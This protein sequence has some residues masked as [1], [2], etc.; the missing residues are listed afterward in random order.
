MNVYFFSFSKRNN[1]TK[2]PVLE[3]GTLHDCAFKDATSLTAP[4]I[5]L[6]KLPDNIEPTGYNYAYIPTFHRYYFV[7]DW[8]WSI[9]V[10]S[11]QLT[12]DALASF[13]TQIGA[14]TQYVTRSASTYDGNIIDSQYPMKAQITSARVA[15]SRGIWTNTIAGGTFIV[16]IFSRSPDSVGGV[17]YY[18]MTS[19]QL[20]N[21]AQKLMENT[22]WLSIDDISDGLQKALVDPLQYIQSV[23]WFP[24]GISGATE[25]SSLPY[26]WWTLSGVSAK[27]LSSLALELVHVS[28]VRPSHPQSSSRGAYVNKPPFTNY[29]LYLPPFGLIDLDGNVVG[30]FDN[31]GIDTVIDLTSGNAVFNISASSPNEAGTG[32]TTLLSKMKANISVEIS[33]AKISREAN[34]QGLMGSLGSLVG[35]AAGSIF[36][37]DFVGS[38]IASSIGSGG[39]SVN[40]IGSQGDFSEYIR[41]VNY[42]SA[43]LYAYFVSI[44]P[45]DNNH[46]GRPLCQSKVI[47]TLSGFIQCQGAELALPATDTERATIEN[48]MNGGF[49][50]E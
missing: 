2:R 7:N 33:L 42:G 41:P 22:D 48:F 38:R 40:S 24:I 13:K 16:G 21:L 31:V 3:T 14:S 32:P 45:M 4:K 25:V 9:G 19:A 44:A 1:S 11:V 37:D 29:K 35:S 30:S 6:K 50:Y 15:G 23:R 10:W 47:N 43:Y 46:F 49:F 28:M 20:T 34:T 17:T 18:T 36:G 8:E 26:G 27:R 39:T 5:V 12:V